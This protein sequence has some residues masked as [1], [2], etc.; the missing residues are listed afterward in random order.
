MRL[1]L[2][3]VLFVFLSRI[4]GQGFRCDELM[5]SQP[6]SSLR[7]FEY[8]N[9]KTKKRGVACVSFLNNGETVLI[10]MEEDVV[11]D[12]KTNKHARKQ[13]VAR[14]RKQSNSSS[15]QV[16][17]IYSG[18][19]H[20]INNRSDSHEDLYDLDNTAFTLS[21]S[22]SDKSESGNIAT[23]S[24]KSLRTTDNIVYIWQPRD[25]VPRWE[26]HVDIPQKCH[27]E[28][29]T[30][31]QIY[32]PI[33]GPNQRPD[34][35]G[36]VCFLSQSPNAIKYYA[37]GWRKAGVAGKPRKFIDFGSI[38][39]ASSKFLNVYTGR[40]HELAFP[41][42]CDAKDLEADRQT[43]KESRSITAVKAYN[44]NSYMIYGDLQ[45]LWIDTQSVPVDKLQ[46]ANRPQF[47]L[48][49]VDLNGDYSAELSN[50]PGLPGNSIRK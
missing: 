32:D 23:F 27:D 48:L 10:Y 40:L 20:V 13:A 5:T 43:F 15:N 42:G 8:R 29:L 35:N 21:V 47:P 37:L 36:L 11:V 4:S 50:I 38:R 28:A 3:L 9:P 7:T 24:I 1:I 49:P 19:I 16:S 46:P 30:S 17:S 6:S 39:L 41:C 31:F 12:L 26:M 44:A 2:S 45:E 33:A 14:A 22:T 18:V 25:R 34:R